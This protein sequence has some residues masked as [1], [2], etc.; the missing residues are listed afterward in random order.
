MNTIHLFYFSRVDLLITLVDFQ[1]QSQKAQGLSPI[2]VAFLV[3]IIILY[4]SLAL[5]TF[6]V[7]YFNILSLI[8]VDLE[9]RY[10]AEA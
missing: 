1:I 10:W 8:T 2:H 5:Y 6:L 7:F 3:H 9:Q 4:L